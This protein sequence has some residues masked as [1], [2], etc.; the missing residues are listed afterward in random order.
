MTGRG[1][2]PRFCSDQCRKAANG[3]AQTLRRQVERYKDLAAQNAEPYS[4]WWEFKAAEAQAELTRQGGAPR[5]D[6]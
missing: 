4:S 6:G 1:R 5:P 3:R 2:P